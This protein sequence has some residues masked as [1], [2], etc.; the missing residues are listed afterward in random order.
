MVYISG[1]SHGRYLYSG[2]KDAYLVS[3]FDSAPTLLTKALMVQIL[4]LEN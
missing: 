2:N 1:W 3:S 4:P